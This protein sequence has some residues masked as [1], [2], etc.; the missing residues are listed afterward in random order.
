MKTP[1]TLIVGLGNPILGD[2]GIGWRVAEKVEQRL[3]SAPGIS[4]R[5]ET[6]CL[7]L[8][9]LSLMEHLV[10]YESAIIIDAI[11]LERGPLGSVYT[12]PLDELANQAVGHLGSA[13]DTT[14]MTALDVGRSMGAE[15]PTKI[16]I[17]G[18]ESPYTYD[19]TEEL[20]APV[21]AA[22]PKAVEVVFKL[23]N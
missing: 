10:G 8:G 16:D 15:L 21:Q 11:N 12:F 22:I 7:A 5:V 6:T 23:L 14:L 18:I 2:D 17:V 4:P 13:H 1:K 20:T 3:K 19:F 9:G